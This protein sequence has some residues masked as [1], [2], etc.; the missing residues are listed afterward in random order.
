MIKILFLF[1]FVSCGLFKPKPPEPIPNPEPIPQH[2]FVFQKGFTLDDVSDF[3]KITEV[4][5][6]MPFKPWVRIVFDYPN[7]IADY[8]YAVDSICRV[9]LCVGQPSDSTYSKKMTVAQYKKR[10]ED[11]VRAFK[12]LIPIWE[13]GNEINGDWLSPDIIAQAEEATRIVKSYGLKTMLVTYWNTETCKDSHGEYK[14]WLQSNVT[15][16]LKDNTNY[17]FISIYGYDCDGPEPSYEV[18]LAEQEWHLNF[19]NKSH[20]AI[21]EYGKKGDKSVMRHYLDSYSVGPGLYWFGLQDII[22]GNL[23]DEFIK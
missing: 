16:Y 9:A 10:F 1:I 21:G 3:Q 7:S 4:I 5:K 13:T 17:A 23:Y 6:K 12:H 18:L 22:N 20:V 14:K 19:F 2:S 8:E 15:Q 11:Y